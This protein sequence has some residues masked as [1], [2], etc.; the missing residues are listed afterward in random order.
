VTRLLGREGEAWELAVLFNISHKMALN[1]RSQMVESRSQRKRDRGLS[2]GKVG[3]WCRQYG[4]AY[5]PRRSRK[6]G[7]P[8]E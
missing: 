8:L 7:P 2:V 5:G 4:G 1:I 6:G 3:I